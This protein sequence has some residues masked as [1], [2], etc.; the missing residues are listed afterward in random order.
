MHPA[1]TIETIDND[2]RENRYAGN[3]DVVCLVLS[4]YNNEMSGYNF[5]FLCKLKD[6]H[7]HSHEHLAF[8]CVGYSAYETAPSHEPY[9]NMSELS[10]WP[11]TFFYPELFHNTRR[12][13]QARLSNSWMYLGGVDL[14]L[15]PV[16]RGEISWDYGMHLSTRKC[17][18]DVFSDAD[19]MIRFVIGMAEFYQGKFL[20]SEIGSVISRRELLNKVGVFS[21]K[22]G[23]LSL[24]SFLT[25]IGFS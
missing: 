17:C 9:I 1:P 11:L 7:F 18:P 21:E 23:A 16:E 19:E 12:E 5:D 3:K 14:L 8:Y 2:V 25:L 15:L 22:Y 24:G 13:V 20:V 4:S 10:G 6:Y